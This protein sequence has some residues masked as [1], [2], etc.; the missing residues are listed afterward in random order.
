MTAPVNALVTGDHRTVP[1]GESTSATFAVR[2]ERVA[3]D[4]DDEEEDDR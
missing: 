1:P 4:P 2:V 3:P